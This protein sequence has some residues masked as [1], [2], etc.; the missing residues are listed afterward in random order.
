MGDLN[1]SMRCI[2]LNWLYNVHRRFKL[3]DKTLFLGVYIFDAYL[4]KVA[5]NRNELQLYGCTCLWIASKYHEIYAPEANDFAYISDHSF[6]LDEIFA[7][8]LSVLCEL[9][10]R[11]ADIVT[12]LQFAERFLHIAVYPICK[13]YRDRGTQKALEDGER[14][15]D[16]VSNLTSYFCELALFD[17]HLVSTEPA[18]KIAAASLAFAILSISLYPQW[19]DFLKRNTKYDYAALRPLLLRIE[20]LRKMTNKGQLSSVRKKHPTIK[21]WLDRLNVDAVI[22]NKYR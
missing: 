5:I 9:K 20:A 12:P 15:V 14:Y 19:P 4:S 18:S 8:E 2:L 11:F 21:K 13:K 17:C 3:L 16:L 10:F 6:E 7:A 1:E 22:H